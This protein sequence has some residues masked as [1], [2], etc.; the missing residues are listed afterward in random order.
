[1]RACLFDFPAIARALTAQAAAGSLGHSGERAVQAMVASGVS[2]AG[3]EVVG[4][5]GDEGLS[6]LTAEVSA[7][8]FYRMGMRWAKLSLSTRLVMLIHP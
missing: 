5:A 4:S 2:G 8:Y 7:Y 1:M 6:L 3:D